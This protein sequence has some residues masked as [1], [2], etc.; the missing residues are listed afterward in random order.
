MAVKS[1]SPAGQCNLGQIC[2]S[3]LQ[4][5]AMTLPLNWQMLAAIK[6]TA[7]E[8]VVS[9]WTLSGMGWVTA[10]AYLPCTFTNST[11]VLTMWG[12]YHLLVSSY[13]LTTELD[14]K[15]QA[16]Q[17]I[18]IWQM[19]KGKARGWDP[20]LAMLLGKCQDGWICKASH[21]LQKTNFVVVKCVCVCV[22]KGA[23]VNY[24]LQWHQLQW[25][26]RTQ[27]SRKGVIT[28]YDPS[29]GLVPTLWKINYIVLFEWGALATQIQTITKHLHSVHSLVLAH[30]VE[31]WDG[32]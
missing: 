12:P 3:S 28:F 31:S 27:D 10:R 26:W 30:V 24:L 13:I 21:I 6:H 9:N 25:L 4:R 23:L 2:I 16:C 18:S 22:C 29:T 8:R 32:L 1:D 19:R 17:K 15:T 11:A 7:P 5:Q 14:R 20:H